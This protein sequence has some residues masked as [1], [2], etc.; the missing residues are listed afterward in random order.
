MLL[1]GRGVNIMRYSEKA[2]QGEGEHNKWRLMRYI[3][4]ARPCIWNPCTRFSNALNNHSKTKQNNIL[5]YN[6]DFMIKPAVYI[7]VLLLTVGEYIGFLI[8][9]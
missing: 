9:K 3:I 1:R 5:Y 2:L 8:L 6:I 4:C 7:L